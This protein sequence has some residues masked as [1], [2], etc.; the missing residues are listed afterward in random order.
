MLRLE[1][2]A[3]E[4]TWFLMTSW[5][6]PTSPVLTPDLHLCEKGTSSFLAILILVFL[7]FHVMRKSLVPYNFIRKYYEKT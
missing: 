7:C 3:L 4:G 5:K 2:I 1:S 6:P